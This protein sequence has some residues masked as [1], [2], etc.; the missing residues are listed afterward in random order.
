MN[1]EDFY[2]MAFMYTKSKED[3]LDIVQESIYKALRASDQVKEEA[4][5]KTWFYR[6]LIN[7]SLTHM[8]RKDKVVSMDS[9]SEI[10]LQESLDKED[11]VD[12]YDALDRLADEDKTLIILRFFEDMKFKDIAE[13]TGRNINSVKTRIYSALNK[14]RDILDCEVKIDA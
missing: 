10:P 13:L 2:K 1:Q 11:K 14:L 12:L 8:K 4:Y 3:A 9:I 7:T 5:M 6:I